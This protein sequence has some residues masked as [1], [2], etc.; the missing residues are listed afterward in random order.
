MS[1]IRYLKIWQND[2][3]E[4]SKGLIE[5]HGLGE[6]SAKKYAS[7]MGAMLKSSGIAGEAVRDMSKD[8]L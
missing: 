3:N 1:Q 6:L 2:I 7:Y 8:M 4:F 5:S